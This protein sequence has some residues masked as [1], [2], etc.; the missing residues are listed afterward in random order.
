LLGSSGGLGAGAAVSVGSACRLS[1]GSGS[2]GIEK[3]GS[4]A[5]ASSFDVE[6]GPIAPVAKRI[7]VAPVTAA[8]AGAAIQNRRG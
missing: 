8:V 5:A 2:L 1:S 3:R 7:A 4:T 6:R